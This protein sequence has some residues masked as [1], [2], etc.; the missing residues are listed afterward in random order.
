MFKKLACIS[1]ATFFSFFL[2]A[3]TATIRGT[4]NSESTGEA[5]LFALV[6]IDGTSM[7][8]QTDV[9]GFYSLTKIP[10]GTY[11][12]IAQEPS[13]TP[14]KFQ[15]T[16]K[17]GD[18]IT[19]NFALKTREM[20]AVTISAKHQDDQENPEVGK[21]TMDT[22]DINRVVAIGGVAD[23][24]QSVQVLPGV[25]STGDQ[26]GQL[27]IRGG[28]PVQNKV[29]LDGMIIYNPFHSIGLFS[30]F[31]TDIIKN[32]DVYTG[33]FSADYGGRVSSIMDI[34]TRDGNRKRFG[35][36]ITVSPFG[37]KLMVEGPIMR[38]DSLGKHG[39]ITYVASAKNSY[40]RQTSRLLYGYANSDTLSDGSAAGLP[41]NFSDYYGKVAFNSINGS[42]LNVFGFLFNDTVARYKGSADLGW[43]SLG[44]GSN[45]QVV[46]GS[47]TTLIKGN[48]AYSKYNIGM[49]EDYYNPRNSSVNGFNLGLNFTYFQRKN[50]V[51]YGIEVL[52]FRTDFSFENPVHRTISQVENTTEMDGYIKYKWISGNIGHSKDTNSNRSL[53]L[54][55]GFRLQYYA[56]LNEVSPEP[57]L[58]FKY[59]INNHL[60]LKGATGMYSQNLLSA[61][62][63]RDVVNLFYGFLSGSDN[64]PQTFTD[65]DGNVHEV[66]SRLQKANH[67]IFGL[68]WNP[69]DSV[70]KFGE[71]TFNL[72]GYL[73]DFRQLTNLNR[74]KLYDDNE[75]N[76][77]QPDQLKKDFI[78]ETGKAYGVDFVAKYEYKSF[79]FWGVYSLGF[80]TRWDGIQSYR[81]NFDRRHNIN[82]VTSYVFGKKNNWEADIRWNFGTGFPFTP[83][84]GFYESLNFDNITTDYTTQN[85]TLGV[86]Y[87][88]LNSHQ[89]PAY[90]R[91]DATI[92]R[93]WEF[94][95]VNKLEV[96]FSVTNAYNRHNVFYFDRIAY[97]RVDQLPIMPSLSVNWSF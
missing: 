29:L 51:N 18:I 95:P 53:V 76:A 85:G 46:P 35:G 22:K 81:P 39:S 21:T 4:V 9:N 10:A 96:A 69:I 50:V 2:T 93:V 90:S 43:K 7:G 60:R 28:T 97:K 82:I 66:K 65:Q 24:A 40:L 49:N 59:N 13:Y 44:F 33:G 5:V 73:K 26:G 88:K 87:G 31:D 78:I 30:V 64:I 58:G 11:T 12:L 34:T 19:H 62:S 86:L 15:I 63:D 37:A 25:V 41:F 91:L 57:R 67:Y 3:Q 92:K 42:K 32:L 83:T 55:P 1:L 54:E 71:I 17:A 80:V 52:G 14:S 70:Q 75:A 27:Y 89:L 79:Y 8:V 61:T 16:V 56:T 38:P 84:G 47:S 20:E 94:S 6:F 74:N 48:F 72:E 45:F 68:E 23:I 77:S 36:K